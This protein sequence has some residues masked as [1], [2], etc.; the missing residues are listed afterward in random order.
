MSRAMVAPLHLATIRAAANR[1]KHKTNMKAKTA[2]TKRSGGGAPPGFGLERKE[3]RWQCVE[4]CGACCKL[5]KGPA[6]VT[7]E[8]IFTDPSDVELY[9]SLI[10]PDGWCINFD[11]TSRTCSIYSDR[12]YFCRVEPEIFQTLYGIDKKRFYKEACSCCRDTIKV[13][14]GSKSKELENFNHTIK[15]VSSSCNE[16]SESPSSSLTYSLDCN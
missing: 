6:F 15:S 12:P 2:R 3:P 13:V 16:C 11:K 14:Y 9:R 10:G 4:G 1:P 8:E 5:E 7:P